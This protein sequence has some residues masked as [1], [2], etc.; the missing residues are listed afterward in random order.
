MVTSLME[1]LVPD[2]DPTPIPFDPPP[3]YDPDEEYEDSIT[4]YESYVTI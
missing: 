2:I 1:E 3:Y 4:I